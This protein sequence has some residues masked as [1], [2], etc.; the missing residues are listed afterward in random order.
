MISRL[1]RILGAAALGCAAALPAA[2]A[3]PCE[4]AA[5][6]AERNAGLPAGLLAAIGQVESGRR[7]AGG[8]S[9]WPWTVNIR[10]QGIFF[11]SA[12]EAIAYVDA[13]LTAGIRSVDVGCFQ[14]NLQWHPGAFATLGD[15]F[16]PATNAAYAARFLTELAG[17][18]GDWAAA[19]GRYHSASAALGNPYRSLV[20]AAW[21]GRQADP[22]RRSGDTD[23][24]V[25][26]MSPQARSVHVWYGAFRLEK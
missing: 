13:L 6:A 20:L 8:R 18:S 5:A 7:D 17:G 21:G 19:A 1:S 23:P 12:R 25:V 4:E 2:A 26:R 24:F 22:A 3:G 16:D 11:P 14:V 10:G 15:A 9:G